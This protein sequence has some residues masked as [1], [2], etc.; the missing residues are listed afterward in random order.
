MRRAIP[1]TKFRCVDGPFKGK[2]I[3]LSADARSA[4]FT[5]RGCTGRYVGV[6]RGVRSCVAVWEAA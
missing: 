3:W 1:K 5:V 2:N 4:T 6:I